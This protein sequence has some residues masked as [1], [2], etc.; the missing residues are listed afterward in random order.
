MNQ[1][2]DELGH[3]LIKEILAKNNNWGQLSEQSKRILGLYGIDDGM[4]NMMKKTSLRE[5]EGYQLL[6]IDNLSELPKNDIIDYLKIKQPQLEKITD[7]KINEINIGDSVLTHMNTYE[8]VINTYDQG[9]KEIWNVI[10]STIDVIETTKNH[11]FLVR[12]KNIKNKTN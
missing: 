10:C 8:K 2:L 1:A 12:T 4:W 5:F 6:T 9:K 7:K 3:I 11:K